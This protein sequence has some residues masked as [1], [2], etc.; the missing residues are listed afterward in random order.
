MNIVV[1]DGKT[2]NPGD[3][4]W[5]HLEAL[6]N[7]TVYDR[8]ATD[9]IVER[10]ADADVVLT[11]K[12][13]LTA[14]TLVLLPKLRYIS[15][16]ATGY[17]VVDIKAA[18]N[19][20][21]PVSN[22]PGYSS[23]S[24]VQTVFAFLLEHCHHVQ[25]HTDSVRAGEWSRSPD[26]SYTKF[27]LIELAGKTMGI[28]GYGQIGQQVARAALALGMNIVVHTRTEK[29]VPGLEQVQFVSQDELFAGADV[30]SLHSP[31]TP[32]TTGLINK[33]NLALMK[34]TAF[35]INTARGGHV[36][37]QDL[38]DALNEGRIAG[39][40]LD[41]LSVE[42]PAADNPLLSAA[43]CF[44]TPH[45]AW[46]TQEARARLLAITVEN[47]RLFAEGKVQNRVN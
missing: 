25:A 13:P 43:N 21:I 4:S 3:L 24:V 9:E 10:A 41:V 44:I 14:E 45:F 37:E 11:N 16:L 47:V 42:P 19:R 2:L 5:N 20:G 33:K 6:G 34:P 38:A 29:S 30:I 26:F 8:T 17:N 7:L 36:N 15:V 27:P 12:T 32:E 23:M 39:A 46:A 35:L 1:L 31:L 22:V 40:G 28:F 18:A